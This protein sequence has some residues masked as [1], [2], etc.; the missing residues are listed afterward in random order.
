MAR[1]KAITK[2]K[3]FVR[4]RAKALANGN[5]SLYLDIYKN[6]KRSYEFLKLYI[7]P[8]TTAAEKAANKNTLQLAEKIRAERQT[9]IV[10]DQAGVINPAQTKITLVDYLKEY[11]KDKTNRGTRQYYNFRCCFRLVEAFNSKI[12]LKDVTKDFYLDF[13]N[14]L[15]KIYTK[16]PKKEDKKAGK[17]KGTPL[18]DITIWV[19]LNVLVTAINVAVQKELIPSNPFNK[20]AKS[21]RAKKPESTREYLTIEELQKME[22]TACKATAFE[23]IKAAFLLSCYVGLRYSDIA[24][25][26]WQHITTDRGKTQI[27]IKQQKV[28]DYV[29]IP[30]CQKALEYL[31]VREE[32]LLTDNVFSL[33]NHKSITTA[34]AKWAKEAGITKKVTF[35][36][37]R[38]TFATTLLTLGA[39]IY[40][41]SK[42]LGHTNIKTTQI[43]AKIVDKKK[44]EAI[45]LFNRLK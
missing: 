5:K 17:D 44:E 30:L 12:L 45:D 3:Q 11:V 24:A 29:V 22:A 41:T 4:V 2:A 25:L 37:A 16:S 19:Y 20:V 14:Y 27:R 28:N 36:V 43:Y 26:K 38:H 42:L 39:D 7:V 40:T 23:D 6:G 34:I 18:A 15:K 10:F 21:D 9:A 1:K 35:H 33:P 32:K 13:H 31:P 8:E